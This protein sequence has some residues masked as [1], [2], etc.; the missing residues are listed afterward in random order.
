MNMARFLSFSKLLAEFS[1]I[2]RK[3]YIPGTDRRENDVEHS[4]HLAMMAWYLVQSE[5]L[6][7]D[8]ERVFK[9][10]LAHDLVEIYA[11]DTDFYSTDEAYVAGK[12]EREAA[13]AAR[14][15]EEY[16]DMPQVHEAI[17]M[18]MHKN[19][20]ESRFVYALDKILPIMRNYEDGGREWREKGIT[21]Q[22][23]TEKKHEKV[24]VSPEVQPY[25]EEL[26]ALLR[27]ADIMA[28]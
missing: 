23:L 4:Y 17:D 13:A 11:G 28:K 25:Y 14:L 20:R 24:A 9:Y 18:Y 27:Q 12:L 22:M 1:S 16:P 19:D 7:L 15:Q 3:I 21:L 8:L 10:A 26:V 6:D 2:E 5:K